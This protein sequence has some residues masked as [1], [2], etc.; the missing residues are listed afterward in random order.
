MIGSDV[1]DLLRRGVVALE[2]IAT[3]LEKSRE[4]WWHDGNSP[5]VNIEHIERRL[6][7]IDS[8][9]RDAGDVA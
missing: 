1:Y 5:G 3:A 4:D 9:I 8:A 6:D 2:R 7:D